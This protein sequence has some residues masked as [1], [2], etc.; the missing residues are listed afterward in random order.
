MLGNTT[1]PSDDQITT[2]AQHDVLDIL[3]ELYEKFYFPPFPCPLP[4]FLEI[5]NINQLRFEA[6]S[7]VVELLA[8][9]DGGTET[10]E[11]GAGAAAAAAA[12]QVL[13]R[14]AGFDPEAWALTNDS[15]R[16][17][18]LLI[19]RIYQ[20]AILLYAACSLRAQATP[21]PAR[22][23][24]HRARLF[25]LL[26]R[27]TSLMRAKRCMMW[28][29][30]VAGVHAADGRPEERRWVGEE[31]VKMCQDMGTYA[32]MTAK[33]LL[34]RFWSSGKTEWDECFDAPYVFVA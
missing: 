15:L 12:D 22:A 7:G 9:D 20:S 14:L 4:L 28:P 21:A 8:D 27:A 25:E 18:W 10:H 26:A 32:P 34:E 5:I 19:A 6:A 3:A 31:L 11:A 30:V 2:N 23:A 16:D 1:S 24:K 29:L 17:D 33:G 13:D